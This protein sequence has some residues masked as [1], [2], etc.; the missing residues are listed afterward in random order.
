MGQRGWFVKSSC[1]P[2]LSRKAVT[3]LWKHH[4]AP[5]SPPLMDVS[6]AELWR[7]G[8]VASLFARMRAEAPVHFCPESAFGPYWSVVRY[9]E[10]VHVES[11]PELYSSSHLHGGIT[12]AGHRPNLFPMFIAMDPPEHGP[13]R[14]SVAPAFAPSELQRLRPALLARTRELVDSLPIDEPFDWV[15]RVSV[16]LTTQMLATLFGFPREERR[17]LAYWSEWAGDIEGAADPSRARKRLE[18]LWECAGAF[19]RLW[20]QRE[21]EPPAGDLISIMCHSDA[22]R[23]MPPQEFLGNLILLIVGGNDTTRHAMSALPLV[24][25]LWPEA[26]ERLTADPSPIP[27]AAQELIRWQT[28]LAHMRRTATVDGELAGERIKARDKVILWYVSANRDERVFEEGDR[29]IP[30]R[31]NARRHLAFGHGIHRCV[32]ARLAELQLEALLEVLIE[33]RLKPAAIGE[34][35]RTASCFSHGYRTMPVRLLRDDKIL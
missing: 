26:W 27:F 31:P 4:A 13:Q 6:C 10:I 3:R 9:D 8:K 22:T 35:E 12:I 23:D 25:S 16:E 15:E 11:Q 19:L 17:R 30:N 29:F 20:R 34:I 14:R 21:K 33:R 28:P 5:Q 18:I 24:N 32:G 1:S 2:S 7:D